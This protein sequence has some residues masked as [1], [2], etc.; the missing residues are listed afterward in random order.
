M[1]LHDSDVISQLGELLSIEQFVLADVVDTDVR[2]KVQEYENYIFI[3]CKMMMYDEE[4]DFIDIEHLSLILI[5]D[6]LISFQE[7]EGDVFE[8]IRQRIRD[9]KKRIRTNGIDYLAYALLDIVIDNYTYSLGS[10]GERIEKLELDLI[11]DSKPDLLS[12]LNLYKKEVNYL[13]RNIKTRL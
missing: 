8:P 7:K 11:E 1:V 2:P 6:L 13:R 5:G 9:H 10:V 3:T 12:T 4:K